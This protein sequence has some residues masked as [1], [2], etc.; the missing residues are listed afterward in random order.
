MW[1]Q[2]E[3]SEQQPAMVKLYD[4]GIRRSCSG[5]MRQGCSVPLAVDKKVEGEDRK[6]RF[7]LSRTQHRASAHCKFTSW[8]LESHTED[9]EI[10]QEN[11]G[12]TSYRTMRIVTLRYVASIASCFCSFTSTNTFMSRG[13]Y[14]LS[15]DVW[16]YKLPSLCIVKNSAIF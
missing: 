1:K 15:W 12:K 7:F 16:I 2:T 8:S 6:W 14:H 10:L 5:L 3:C 13:E 4:R 9:P 11:C